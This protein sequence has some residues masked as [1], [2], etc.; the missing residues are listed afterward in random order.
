MKYSGVLMVL[1]FTL[2]SCQYAQRGHEDVIVYPLIETSA[3]KP[4]AGNPTV[5]R[6]NTQTQTVICWKLLAP[7]GAEDSHFNA[8]KKLVNCAVRDA[9]NWKCEYS[10]GSGTVAIVNGATRKSD[11]FEAAN[12]RYVSK[13]EWEAAEA[14]WNR[15]H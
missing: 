7:A 2:W 15:T 5:Y 1:V 12:I 8:P 9:Q 3:G 11:P 13:R 14:A 4:L 10:D 6:I